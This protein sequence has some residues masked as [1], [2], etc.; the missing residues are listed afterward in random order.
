MDAPQDSQLGPLGLS[1]STTRAGAGGRRGRREGY[2]PT[3]HQRAF[4]VTRP[5]P[6]ERR[7]GGGVSVSPHA[8][9][10]C[11]QRAAGSWSRWSAA[12]GSCPEPGS[13]KNRPSPGS[14]FT[15]TCGGRV[16]PTWRSTSLNSPRKVGAGAGGTW[17]QSN[18]LTTEEYPSW[19]PLSRLG[20]GKPVFQNHCVFP[21]QLFFREPDLIRFYIQPT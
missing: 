10:V 7:Q 5:W 1:W 15:A 13:L 16:S 6:A 4:K 12:A 9:S 14:S 11:R 8:L 20:S 2:P 18:T 19:R 21:L 17:P 3:R